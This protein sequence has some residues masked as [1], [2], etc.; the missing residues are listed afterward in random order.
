M[1]TK[2]VYKAN[3]RQWSNDFPTHPEIDSELIIAIARTESSMDPLAFNQRTGAMG[4]F[5]LTPICLLDLAQRWGLFIS[6]FFP[7]E[8]VG[9]AKKYYSWLFK[10]LGNHEDAL[11]AWN[12]GIGYVRKWIKNGRK[13]YELPEETRNFTK[14]VLKYWKNEEA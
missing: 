8:G 5:Q 4:L 2:T 9:G 13:E 11:R 3:I 1:K 12:W 14:R 6:P 10:E 7:Q